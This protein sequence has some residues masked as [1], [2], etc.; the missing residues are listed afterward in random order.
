MSG[1]LLPNITYAAQGVPLY[2]SSSGGGGGGGGGSQSST[3]QNLYVSSATVSSFTKTNSIFS[4]TS[5][6]TLAANAST[7]LYTFPNNAQLAGM[8][9]VTASVGEIPPIAS[10]AVFSVAGETSGGSTYWGV[11]TVSQAAPKYLLSMFTDGAANSVPS[12]YIDNPTGSQQLALVSW[13][14]MG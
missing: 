14:Q 4:A 13:L 5:S 1:S 2:A 7:L 3:I 12:L 11:T 8:Y 9:P 10:G 6:F